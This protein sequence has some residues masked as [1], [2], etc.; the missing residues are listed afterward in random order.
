MLS[1][2]FDGV[3]IVILSPWFGRFAQAAHHAA[4]IGLHR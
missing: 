1:V 4:V 2:I 3:R